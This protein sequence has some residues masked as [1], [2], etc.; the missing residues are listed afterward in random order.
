MR[1]PT[2]LRDLLTST[3]STTD[4]GAIPR[5]SGEA[6]LM[7]TCLV[8]HEQR[9][10]TGVACA[11]CLDELKLPVAITP[12]QVSVQ[13]KSPAPAALVDPWGRLHRLQ[14]KS[15]IG[16]EHEEDG[17]FILDAAVSRRHATLEVAGTVWTLKDLAS[18][19]GT[20]VEDVAI[21]GAQVLRDGERIR[22]GPIAFFFLDDVGST[23]QIDT[24]LDGFT[25]R[26]PMIPRPKDLPR[27]EV[28]DRVIDL[29]E[30]TGGGGGVA[31]IDGKPIQLTL[32]QFELVSILYERVRTS[33]EE[34]SIRG[35]VHPTE[36]IRT[37]SL[38]SAEP[39]EDHVRQLVRR[40]RRIFFK[41]GIENVIESRYGAGYRLRLRTM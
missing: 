6:G 38:E 22:F 34:E 7:N 3:T 1:S 40:L 5:E 2:A 33:T 31:I 9:E 41:A 26:G 10:T 18:S 12:E 20:Y 36:L 27:V 17:L 35:F 21:Q 11:E 30:P 29:R 8:C 37:L 14:R 39:S 24:S 32:P 4:P 25:V 19:N 23:P 16:R 13:G 15:T 28:K